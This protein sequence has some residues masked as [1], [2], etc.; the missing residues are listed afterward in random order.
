MT[1][2]DLLRALGGIEEQYIAEAAFYESA[3]APR[4]AR[5]PWWLAAAAALILALVGCAV[6]YALQLEN[7][8][9]GEQS[10]YREQWSAEEA[11]MTRVDTEETVL[12]LSGLKG[13]AN[14]RAALEWFEFLESYD[15]DGT[16]REQA[17]LS[18]IE[19]P[20]LRFS[21]EYD[22]YGVYS[23]EMTEKIDDIAA[24]YALKRMGA[25]V[26]A[27]SAKSLLAYLSLED[28]VLSESAAHAETKWPVYYEGGY[29]Q[30]AFSVQLQGGEAW[31]YAPSCEFVFSPKDCF[32]GDFCTLEGEN[33]REWNYTTPSG[34]ELLILRSDTDW[35]AWVF[36]DRGDATVSLR[37]ETRRDLLSDSGV[38][39]LRLSDRQLEQLL[40]TID[41]SL[42][43]TPGDA[44][45]LRGLPEAVPEGYEMRLKSAQTD[46]TMAYI[47]LGIALPEEDAQ[48]LR[49]GDC[50]LGVG[51]WKPSVSGSEE[52]SRYSWSASAR[53][54]GDGKDST[55]DY[56]LR[57]E[58]PK[59]CVQSEGA[60]AWS[61]Y[62][63]DLYCDRWS[64]QSGSFERVWCAEGVWRF[65]FTTDESLLG[66]LEFVGE[67]M[68]VSVVSGWAMSP[69]GGETALWEERTLTSLRLRAFGAAAEFADGRGGQL[70]GV[71][72][73][74]TVTLELADGREIP[75]DSNLRPRADVWPDET[76]PLPLGEVAALRLPDGARLEPIV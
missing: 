71:S 14:Y 33:W 44:A 24:R 27:Y 39:E 55:M 59:G 45:L 37:V 13:S 62:V 75:L 64:A 40:D 43:P 26:E 4:R 69:E 38:E 53:E 65:E 46:G 57:L 73:E 9:L 41:F 15:P 7:L 19:N 56:V 2:Q 54:D 31:P 70:G 11:A 63:E 49:E 35:R 47:V 29:F 34:Y 12:T 1:G 23:E 8:K 67:P 48:I 58:V 61:L 28:V 3:P 16:I 20:A 36:C 60:T 32:N 42:R 76:T 30:L 22:F 6:A 52:R 18:L 66:E 72:A 68:A 51:L 5:R 74:E 10:G 50:R 21:D 17:E 25:Q